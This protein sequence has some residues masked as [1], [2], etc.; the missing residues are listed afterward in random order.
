M[1]GKNSLC[2][3][4]ISPIRGE[5]SA[6][7]RGLRRTTTAWIAGTLGAG[8]TAS[9]VLAQQLPPSGAGASN[10][11]SADTAPLYGAASARGA[12]YLLR[13]GL[14][15]LNYQQ[16]E[17]GLRFLRE[18]ESHQSEL[19]A[20][21]KLTLKRGI[22][23]RAERHEGGGGR[24]IPLRAERAIAIGQ[25]IHRRASGD[26]DRRE[27]GA[28][29]RP[30]AGR[31]VRSF[32]AE[33]RARRA[34]PSG[35]PAPRRPRPPRRRCEPARLRSG[36][37]STPTDPPASA[38]EIPTLAAPEMPTLTAIPSSSG[39]ADSGPGASPPLNPDLTAVPGLAPAS[40]GQPP[41]PPAVSADPG[42]SRRNL[43]GA[44]P[45]PDG[46]TPVSAELPELPADPAPPAGQVNA[47][48]SGQP[49]S[50]GPVAGTATSQPEVI[51][52]V[53]QA[54]EPSPLTPPTTQLTV[55]TPAASTAD[56]APGA[57]PAAVT[58]PSAEIP[59]SSPPEAAPPP[60]QTPAPILLETPSAI[61]QP[62]PPSG[63]V[64]AGVPTP[65]STSTPPS[66]GLIPAA[67]P[68]PAPSGS[69]PTS[70]E[71]QAAPAGTNSPIIDGDA[72]PLPPLGADAQGAESP[73]GSPH[74]AL[75]ESAAVTEPASATS[76]A[77]TAAPAPLDA[78]PDGSNG[79]GELPPLPAD[80][81]AS[82]WLPTRR[83]GIRPPRLRLRPR[84]LG[85]PRRPAPQPLRRRR[86]RT[87]PC[88]SSLSASRHPLRS[89]PP[90]RPPRLEPRPRRPQRG[91]NARSR[92]PAPRVNPRRSPRPARRR[93]RRQPVSLLATPP[94]ARLPNRHRPP[95]RS[96]IPVMSPAR[97]RRRTARPPRRLRPAPCR[98]PP[99]E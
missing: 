6:R 19:T 68:D 89:G 38:P 86:P 28:V 20:P 60:V 9:I 49:V 18:A 57:L 7:R 14:D 4:G 5:K 58:L 83:T 15:Y 98:P 85:R 93:T 66:G 94:P 70:A 26:R 78:E 45:L 67:M 73:A 8:L 48:G 88:P 47:T 54:P 34:S 1:G 61:D 74:P 24:G 33:T 90:L 3:S 21:E 59:S 50:P 12:R 80:L 53:T 42:S 96:S 51:P 30:R 75:P 91:A 62:S 16:Y 43:A 87:S 82:R 56:S 25:R 35:S 84:Y 36:T 10:A 72:A 64:P 71:P 40:P 29:R 79:P 63:S 31:V 23:R 81:G 2:L 46:V 97:T 37:G 92:T 76:P 99:P 65:S 52:A 77:G 22:E 44:M 11:S 55:E 13:N 95:P 41:A 39:P 27:P 17:R 69:A 32:P